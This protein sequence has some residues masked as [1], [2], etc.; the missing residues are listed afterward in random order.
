MRLERVRTVERVSDGFQLAEEDLKL[1][2]PGDY[3]GT[4]QSGLPDLQVARLTDQDILSLARKEA[5]RIQESDPD[6]SDEGHALLRKRLE[7]LELEAP[8]E[9]S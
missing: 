7:A 9:M 3:L 6:L 1:R 8:G 5:A 2:G 4:R